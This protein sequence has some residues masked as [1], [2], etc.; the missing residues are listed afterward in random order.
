[1]FNKNAIK[2]SYSCMPNI[3]SKINCN[4][5]KML[6]S[7]PTEP[8]KLCNCLVEEDCPTNGLR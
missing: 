2:V 8:Q 3:R 7:K 5:K 4:N 1:M 6:Q